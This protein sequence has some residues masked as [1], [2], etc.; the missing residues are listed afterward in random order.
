MPTTARGIAKQIGITDSL[1]LQ[2][3]CT[4]IKLGSYYI[5][6]LYNLTKDSTEKMVAAYNAGIGNVLNGKADFRISQWIITLNLFPS[7]KQEATY[8]LQKIH[9]TI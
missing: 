5:K 1:N 8:S 6:W 4:S 9:D 3:P 7:M 2:D